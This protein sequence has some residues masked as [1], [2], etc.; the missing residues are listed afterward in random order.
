MFCLQPLAVVTWGCVY[1]LHW[2]NPPEVK[3]WLLARGVDH[4]AADPEEDI[5][6]TKGEG[7]RGCVARVKGGGAVLLG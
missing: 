6:Y 3:D 4:L 5:M 7:G 2:V 1:M